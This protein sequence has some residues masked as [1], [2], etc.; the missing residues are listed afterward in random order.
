MEQLAL[1]L[2]YRIGK[3]PTFYFGFSLGA[4]Y[5]FSRVWDVVEERFRKRLAMWKRQYLS[6]GGRLTLIKSTLSSLSIYF[7]SLLVIP[8]KVSSR[9]EKIQRYFL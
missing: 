7:M 2:G 4:S 9:L 6:T 5:K 8:R 3:L 1:V